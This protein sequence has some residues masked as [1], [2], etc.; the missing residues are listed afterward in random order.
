MSS[1]R[2]SP[3]PSQTFIPF[4]VS[5]QVSLLGFETPDVESERWA[6]ECTLSDGMINA[7]H[8]YGVTAEKFELLYFGNNV[9]V[10]IWLRAKRWKKDVTVGAD[11]QRHPVSKLCAQ[12]LRFV[13]RENEN[14]R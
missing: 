7:L 11:R 12:V 3:L 1:R 5:E 4:H 14:L 13:K 9:Y 8:E 6:F 2:S 10:H